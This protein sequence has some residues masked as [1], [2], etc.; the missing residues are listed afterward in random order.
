M[1]V[2]SFQDFV[3]GDSRRQ[4]HSLGIAGAI[5]IVAVIIAVLIGAWVYPTVTAPSGTRVQFVVPA[6]G[7]GVE[8]GTKVL[9]HGA[10]V[11]EVTEV[12]AENADSVTI[13][14]VLQSASA[15]LITDDVE[16]DFRPENYFGITAV[17][18]AEAGDGIPV[19]DGQVIRR[20][21]APDFTMS[22]MLEQGSLVIDGTLTESMIS[23]L[24][25]V[26]QYADGLAPLIRTGI[27]VADSVAR[28][29]RELPSVLM[30]RMNDVLAEFPAFSREAAGAL[31]S[32]YD[33]AYNRR[34]DGSIGVDDAFMDETD[35]ALELAASDLFGKAGALLASH[36]SELTPLTQLLKS[37]SDPLPA[38]IGSGATI[39]KLITAVTQVESAFTGTQEQKTLQLRI[40]LDD[41]PGLAGPLTRSGAITSGG[42]N[43]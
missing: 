12:S 13:A 8:P 19:V 24:D 28:A 15:S 25:K 34:P 7:P 37:L 26:V 38:I 32:I 10:E 39:D 14:V 40:V 41:L 11:G 29:Q 2:Y 5:A 33:S 31:Y 42:G 23:S 6:L 43:R 17:N 27:V 3:R 22:T 36:D 21:A 1:A 30:N 18:L 35:Q 20:S 9:L 16:V 4:Q